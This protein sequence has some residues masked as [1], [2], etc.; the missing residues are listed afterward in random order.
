[1]QAMYADGRMCH[2]GQGDFVPELNSRGEQVYNNRFAQGQG[3]V[4]QMEEKENG[5]KCYLNGAPELNFDQASGRYVF[6][7]RTQHCYRGPV[8]LGQGRIGGDIN[9]NIS[10]NPNICENGVLCLQDGQAQ[11]N[12]V[13]GTERYAL[14]DGSFLNGIVYDQINSQ[15]TEMISDTVRIAFTDGILS[16]IP[17]R[18][19]AQLDRGEGYFGVCLDV[20]E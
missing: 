16:N 11:W 4:F 19:G 15:L 5:L 13:P 8:F 3:C 7:L 20:R 12:V 18:A 14:R 9:F 2:R 6:S 1:M 10:Y 17:I